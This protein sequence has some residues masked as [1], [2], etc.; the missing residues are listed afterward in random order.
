[1][2][3][4]R[5]VIAAAVLVGAGLAIAAG[6]GTYRAFLAPNQVVG[7]YLDAGADPQAVASQIVGSD[8][9]A[10]Q[11]GWCSGAGPGPDLQK[12]LALTYY[13]NINRGRETEALRKAQQT[14]GVRNAWLAPIPSRSCPND[15]P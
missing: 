7:V 10:Y 8:G 6:F 2:R 13:I 5:F 12:S 4:R 9:S 1:V 3:K 14:P 15:L 11:L